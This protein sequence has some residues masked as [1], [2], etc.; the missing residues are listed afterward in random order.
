MFSFEFK[1]PF[2]I[3]NLIFFLPFSA[4]YMIDTARVNARTV[5]LLREAGPVLPSRSYGFAL[6]REL[7]TPHIKRRM[8]KNGI[9][10]YVVL[11]AKCYLGMLLVLSM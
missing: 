4:A 10:K 6:V 9:Q 1:K 8:V 7:V 3:E 2:L 11:N 5:A